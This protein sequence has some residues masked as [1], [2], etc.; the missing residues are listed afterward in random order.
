[1]P[2]AASVQNPDPY[3]ELHPGDG[4]S[5]TADL[6]QLLYSQSEVSRVCSRYVSDNGR[7]QASVP[8]F[9]T[10]GLHLHHTLKPQIVTDIYSFLFIKILTSIYKSH[11]ITLGIG[12]G[13]GIDL[14]LR[15]SIQES[16][17]P[18]SFSVIYSPNRYR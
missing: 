13:T 5:Q 2:E 7:S 6:Q 14:F 16:G 8:F 12:S 3:K 4:R 18:S 17:C 10:E 15:K 9:Q 1:M 11:P